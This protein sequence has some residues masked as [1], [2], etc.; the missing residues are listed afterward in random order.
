V[1]DRR[2]LAWCFCIEFEWV[3]KLRIGLGSSLGHKA[4]ELGQILRSA[5]RLNVFVQDLIGGHLRCGCWWKQLIRFDR[6]ERGVIYI[7]NR[8]R[9]SRN[10]AAA[11]AGKEVAL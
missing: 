4:R 2:H 7:R 3:S 11:K 6:I 10:A 5:E 9:N 1:R 8:R